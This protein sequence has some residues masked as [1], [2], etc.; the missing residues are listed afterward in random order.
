MPFWNSE[1]PID[2]FQRAKDALSSYA[3]VFTRGRQTIRTARGIRDGMPAIKLAI[4]QMKYLA[5]FNAFVAAAG[6]AAQIVQVYQASRIIEELRG[7]RDELAAGNGLKGPELFAKQVYRFIRTKTKDTRNS[8]E[9]FYFVYHPDND[10]HGAFEELVEGRPLPASYLGMCNSLDLL[11]V[12]M[13][14]IRNAFI[15]NGKWGKRVVFHLL[16]PAYRPLVIEDPFMFSESLKPLKVHGIIAGERPYVKMN[17]HE[18]GVNMLDGV[19][20]WKKPPSWFWQKEEDI[21]RVVGLPEGADE[22]ILLSRDS[23]LVQRRRR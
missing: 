16:I 2:N 12:W 7:I 18:A 10:W 21:P 9:H 4:S 20:I 3:R 22:D 15:R 17:L 23:R 6:V 5:G 11:C 8:M 1:P 13:Q 14:F 19:D